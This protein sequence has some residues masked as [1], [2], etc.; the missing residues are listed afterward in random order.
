MNRLPVRSGHRILCSCPAPRPSR[1][2]SKHA[3]PPVFSG[4]DMVQ[5]DFPLSRRFM[6]NPRLQIISPCNFF[7]VPGHVR[8][9]RSFAS[10]NPLTSLSGPFLPCSLP[11]RHTP[12]QLADL[13]RPPPVLSCHSFCTT[14]PPGKP[15]F[16]GQGPFKLVSRPE[17]RFL[18][19]PVDSTIPRHPG[20]TGK[21]PGTQFRLFHQTVAR[22][23]G[24]SCPSPAAAENSGNGKVRA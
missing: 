21:P 17:N 6:K 13:R 5:Y 12:T 9:P 16:Y 3:S 1:L 18:F 15:A 19:P 8:Y 22:Q 11:F 14:S 4:N 10:R 20:K 7:P 23:N 2:R 24:F